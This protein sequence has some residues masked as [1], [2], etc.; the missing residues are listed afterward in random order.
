[1]TPSAL[2]A[3]FTKDSIPW[4]S[5]EETPKTKKKEA[6]HKSR[7]PQD[8]TDEMN[9]R[10]PDDLPGH[11]AVW[12]A[13]DEAAFLHGRFTWTA[14]DVDDLRTGELRKRIDSDPNYLKV[15]VVGL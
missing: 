11:Y 1:M 8:H 2:K 7:N 10:P 9:P 4:D 6:V 12:A 14:W 3:G 15:G 13:S 5:G